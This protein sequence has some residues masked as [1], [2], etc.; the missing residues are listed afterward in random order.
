MATSMAIPAGRAAPGPST[1]DGAA[2]NRSAATQHVMNG[3]GGANTSQHQQQQQAAMNQQQAAVHAQHHTMQ[4]QLMQSRQQQPVMVP[5]QNNMQPAAA[6]HPSRMAQHQNVAVQP[7]HAHQQQNQAH[8]QQ[9]R[10]VPG[11]HPH[12]RPQGVPQQSL[13]QQQHQQQ[14]QALMQQRQQNPNMPRGGAMHYQQQ[15]Q[16][17][18]QHH[19]QHAQ[20]QVQQQQS[21]GQQQPPHVQH[22]Q[23]QQQ[24]IAHPNQ[25]PQQRSQQQRSQPQYAQ[26]QQQPQQ[27]Q[28][29]M[30]HHQV[31][32]APTTNR[33]NVINPMSAMP[34][35]TSLLSQS[36]ST[37][38]SL[39]N[40]PL[41]D[42]LV[43]EEVKD[44][45]EYIRITENLS[46]RV[47][48]LEKIH[49]DLEHRLEE[50]QIKVQNLE[51][52]LRQREKTWKGQCDTLEK[53]NAE[54]Q[55]LIR[56]EK[57]KVNKLLD[58]VNRLQN[59]IRNMIM[60]KFSGGYHPNQNQYHMQGMGGLTPSS[61]YSGNIKRV[62]S[63]QAATS[64]SI[65][66]GINRTASSSMAHNSPG[67]EGGSLGGDIGSNSQGGRNVRRDNSNAS[68]SAA[69]AQR[70]IS[71][72][73][74]LAHNGSAE[75]VRE[76][77]AVGSLLDFFGM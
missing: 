2:P 41:Y 35:Q 48:D 68:G 66:G 26:Q 57:V 33:N 60:N 3:A 51:H 59:E 47:I 28:R 53:E 12:H 46:R 38:R 65:T 39:T 42:R 61:S 52:T 67:N 34:S 20:H 50:E 24:R 14:Q 22:Q 18:Q 19:V 76:R 43:S 44:L 1:A 10:M 21:Q 72:H 75:A 49:F 32:Q 29:P 11:A 23:T 74:I 73:E 8:Y 40:T 54:S 9:Q 64:S 77:N 4:P 37:E 15:Q 27:Q 55:K 16:Q 36:S 7:Q 5:Q 30:Q 17:P 56:D 58:M 13:Q 69:S 70:H 45:K 62:T 63:G 31:G 6:A 71:P 25:N